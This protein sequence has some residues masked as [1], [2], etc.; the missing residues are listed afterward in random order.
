MMLPCNKQ[1]KKLS[2]WLLSILRFAITLDQDD[3]ATV[4][5]TAA[6]LDRLGANSVF[7]FF[8]KTSAKICN[9]IADKNDPDRAAILCDHLARIEDLRLRGTLA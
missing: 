5:A 1:S 7:S 9:A 8:A 6:C 3:R 4:F 2:D